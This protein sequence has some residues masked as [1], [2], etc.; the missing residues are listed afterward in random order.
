MAL[1]NVGSAPVM[2]PS[3]VYALVYSQLPNLLHPTID[4]WIGYAT[5][6]LGLEHR[7]FTP[8]AW[9]RV[10]EVRKAR[11]K[12]AEG[13]PPSVPWN[14]PSQRIIEQRPHWDIK[15]DKG[16]KGMILGAIFG[17]RTS[18]LVQREHYELAAQNGYTALVSRSIGAGLICIHQDSK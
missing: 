12:S 15:I 14:Q 10:P 13:S 16:I 11:S 3:P 2:I 18:K 8:K 9:I 5:T 1:E 17:G 6:K 7:N 4:R